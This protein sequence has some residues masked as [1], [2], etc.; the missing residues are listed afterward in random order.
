MVIKSLKLK[1]INSGKGYT[2]A[3]DIVLNGSVE[4][5]GTVATARA[6][7]GNGKVRGTHIISRFD[8][9]SGILLFRSC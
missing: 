4:D 9:I 6:V 8:R 5:G 7:L 2:S 1:F 3:P